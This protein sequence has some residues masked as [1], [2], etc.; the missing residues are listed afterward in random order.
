MTKG[1]AQALPEKEQWEEDIKEEFRKEIQNLPA[2]VKAT[3]P[4]TLFN[5]S[6][7]PVPENPLD[8]AIEKAREACV[9]KE[10]EEFH[11]LDVAGKHVFPVHKSGVYG[12]DIPDD[13]K[14]ELKDNIFLHNHPSGLMPERNGYGNSFSKED[15]TTASIAKFSKIITVTPKRDYIM[16]PKN[17]VWPTE[18]EIKRKY[19]SEKSNIVVSLAKRVYLGKISTD[20]AYMLLDHLIWKKIAIGLGLEYIIVRR[21]EYGK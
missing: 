14:A 17:N 5:P 1:L 20:T 8:A 11:L 15:I 2:V 21:N 9:N 3:P 10:Y 12:G 4:A 16:N 13:W 6:V 18:D 7:M 19:D